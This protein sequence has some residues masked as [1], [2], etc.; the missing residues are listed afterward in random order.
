MGADAFDRPL[1]L[2]RHVHAV[3]I[4]ED[5]VLLDAE[6]DMYF[7]IVDGAAH[8]EVTPCGDAVVRDG[9]AFDALREAGL[10]QPEPAHRAARPARPERSMWPPRMASPKPSALFAA[11]AATFKA[12]RGLARRAHLDL[13]RGG[14][15]PPCRTPTASLEADLAGFEH[16]RPWLPLD[17]ECLSRSYHLLLYLRAR[18]HDPRWVFGVR[19]W[20]FRAHCW[21]QIGDA[22]LDDD[23]ERLVAYHPIM[24]T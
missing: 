24:A 16:L 8:V 4:D 10:L 9:A 14:P 2:A 22:V 7:C 19:T 17:G 18:G 21:L 13:I 6:A 15:R 20:P 3:A 5:L 11:I 1:H 12:R 23:V